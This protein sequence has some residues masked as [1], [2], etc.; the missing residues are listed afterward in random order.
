M[1][2]LSHHFPPWQGITAGGEF[3]LDTQAIYEHIHSP[4]LRLPSASEIADVTGVGLRK[5]VT[6]E[7]VAMLRKCRQTA[8]ILIANTG[9]NNGAKCKKY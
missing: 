1:Q 3:R 4:L 2:R 9:S 8:M 7:A 6:M 5:S